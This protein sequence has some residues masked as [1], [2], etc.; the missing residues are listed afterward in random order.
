[1]ALQNHSFK[2]PLPVKKRPIISLGTESLEDIGLPSFSK[3][4]FSDITII[5]RGSYGKVYKAI[6]KKKEFVIKEFFEKIEIDQDTVFNL[7]EYLVTCDEIAGFAGFEH[8]PQHLAKDILSGLN[9][10]H[11]KGVAHRDLKPE[12]VL[13]TNNHVATSDAKYW[14]SERPIVAILSDFGEARSSII[15]TK[16]LAETSTQNLFRGSPAYMAPEAL[17]GDSSSGTIEDLLKMDI[18]SFGM[19]LFHLIYPDTANPYAEEIKENTTVRPIEALKKLVSKKA[20]PRPSEKY[21]FLQNKQLKSIFYK[22]AKFD[23]SCRPTAEILKNCFDIPSVELPPH[24]GPNTAIAKASIDELGSENIEES[25]LKKST[26][27]FRDFVN[28]VEEDDDLNLASERIKDDLNLASE[29]IEDDLNL[30]SESI[31]DDLNLESES[32]EDD[33]N[34]ASERIKDDLNLESES[35]ED[36]LNLESESIED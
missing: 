21:S 35:I 8:T 29:S 25:F 14:W 19:V 24:V 4:D 15:Q 27:K 2:V 16:I 30:E 26:T 9:Y 5:G 20:L 36:D 18:W 13:V 7:K 33:L 6:K 11:G 32:I 31:E 28:I 34:L 12:N 22:C 1:M 3:K 17:L 10:L 23:A